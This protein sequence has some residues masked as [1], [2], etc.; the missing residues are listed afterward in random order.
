MAEL[1]QKDYGSFEVQKQ[2]ML[3]YLQVAIAIEDWHG[4]SDI[5]ND[6]RELEA[7]NTPNYKSN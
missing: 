3:E 6:L 4:V 2:V 7:K 5:A 1:K